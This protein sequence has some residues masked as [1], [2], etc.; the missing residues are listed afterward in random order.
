MKINLKMALMVAAA[1]LLTACGSSDNTTQTFVAASDTTLPANAATVPAVNGTAFTY[2]GGVPALSTTGTTTVAMTVSPATSTFTIS[3]AGQGTASG[4]LTFGS[5]IFAVTSSTFPA[6][7]PLALGQTVTVNPCN[8]NVNTAGAVAN[9]VGTSRSVA[10][11][12]GAASSAGASV[13]ISVNAG[14]QLTLNGVAVGTITLTP[15][16]G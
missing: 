15:V 14:G 5:C 10:L 1:A 9:G 13:T 7:H 12:L 11:V 4:N 3:S 6:G 16:S 8:M 2:P